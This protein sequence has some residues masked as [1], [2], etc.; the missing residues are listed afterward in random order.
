MGPSYPL[1]LTASS[2]SS[3]PLILVTSQVGRKWEED[4]WVDGESFA[5]PPTDAEARS[6]KVKGAVWGVGEGRVS[7]PPTDAEARSLKV[8]GAV[9]GG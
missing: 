9:W 7:E 5:K 3:H 4:G 6:L 1:R 2:P 8:R